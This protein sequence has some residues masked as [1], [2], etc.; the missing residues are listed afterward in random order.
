MS[1]QSQWVG[2]AVHPLFLQ[3]GHQTDILPILLVTTDKSKFQ[4]A[5]K[6]E[7]TDCWAWIQTAPTRHSPLLDFPLGMM[8]CPSLWATPTWLRTAF[9]ALP[10]NSSLGKEKSTKETECLRG[11]NNTG[12][13]SCGFSCVLLHRGP[14]TTSFTCPA[15][16]YYRPRIKFFVFSFSYHENGHG[17]RRG[18][19]SDVTSIKCWKSWYV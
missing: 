19:S 11:S 1:G 9:K 3:E 13:A 7:T 5:E 6:W 14:L 17:Q 8:T 4:N 12:S 16:A 2:G 10:T 15:I 18:C